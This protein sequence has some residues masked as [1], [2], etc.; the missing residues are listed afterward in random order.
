[1]KWLSGWLH[2]LGV[3]K[4]T[5]WG[6]VKH[7]PDVY[8]TLR[9]GKEAISRGWRRL[10]CQDSS[11]SQSIVFCLVWTA[12]A[13]M[14]TLRFLSFHNTTHQA[15]LCVSAWLKHHG[16]A[17][18]YPK[19]WLTNSYTSQN[20]KP[21]FPLV[22]VSLVYEKKRAPECGSHP[23]QSCKL[24]GSWCVSPG[25]AGTASFNR[26]KAALSGYAFGA[27]WLLSRVCW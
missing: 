2:S 11:F 21:F 20:C 22:A 25:V 14:T 9:E 5:G 15:C 8:R 26:K 23:V 1:M 19:L 13:L 16:N 3:P 17:E 10:L 6:R 18:E 27:W 7:I 24:H 4:L 12:L